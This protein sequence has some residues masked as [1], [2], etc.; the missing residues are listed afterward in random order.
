[1]QEL[2][3]IYKNKFT[4][5]CLITL[6]PCWIYSQLRSKISGQGWQCRRIILW[7]CQVLRP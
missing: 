2:Y 7:W 1:M 5:F 6:D 4:L 3:H